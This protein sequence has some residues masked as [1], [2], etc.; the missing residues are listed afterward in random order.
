MAKIQFTTPDGV[1]G[2][3]E[4]TAERMSLGRADDNMIVIDDASISSHHGE[5]AIEGHAWV[6][7]DL[8]STNGTKLGGER[9]ERIELAHGGSFTL[10]SV[11][12]VFVGDY[13]EA[14][15]EPSYEAPSRTVTTTGGYGSIALDR[16]TRTGFGP[17]AKA[18]GNGSGGLIALGVIA[19]LVCAY[20]AFT[21]TQL[22]A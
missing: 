10:G 2:E 15:A 11:E 16:S 6:L 19:L 5:V 18:K 22:S 20:A 8:G 3:V 21:F 4:L 13:E 14:P 9:V 12:C 7:T 17:K 1:S